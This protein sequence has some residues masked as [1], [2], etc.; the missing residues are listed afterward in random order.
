MRFLLASIVVL[1]VACGDATILGGSNEGSGGGAGGAGGS[2]GGSTLGD[3]LPCDIASTLRTRCASCHGSPLAGGAP[4]AILSLADLQAAAPGHPGETVGAR[5]VARMTAATSPMPPGSGP[6]VP[7]AEL[8]AFQ[9]WVTGGLQPGSCGTGGG[10]G[11]GTGGAGGGSSPPANDLPCDLAAVLGSKCIS[12]HGSPLSGG[13]TFTLTSRADLLA[14]S[15]AYAGQTIAQRSLVRMQSATS[16][17]PPAGPGASPTDIATLQGWITAGTPA[18]SCGTGD[19]GVAA[20]TC[21]SGSMW[22]RGNSESFE[23]NPG[24]ACVSCHLGNNFGNQNP[25]HVRQVGEAYFF[26]GTAYPG[27]NEQNTCNAHPP[28]GVN[29]QIIGPDGGV[30]T[31]LVPSPTSGNFASDGY[32]GFSTGRS[33]YNSPV[34]VPFTVRITA[35]NK[36]LTMTTPTTNGDCNQCHT[37]RGLNGAPGRVTWPQ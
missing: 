3:G 35:N 34:P 19:G 28:A 1:G 23:M 26:M 4:Y 14:M 8:T 6:T 25:N 17:M 27:L 22:T 12:C 11:G 7:S 15:A 13:A 30:F 2:G 29:I 16:P 9:A 10:A 24:L 36:T 21:A 5:C 18:G 37:E 33:M 32:A 31:E 20:L